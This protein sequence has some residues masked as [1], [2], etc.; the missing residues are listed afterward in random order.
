MKSILVLKRSSFGDI[1]HTMPVLPPLRRAFPEAKISWLTGV[2]Y[3]PLVLAAGTDEAI[4]IGFRTMFSSARARDYFGGLR[5]LRERFDVL[6]DFQGTVKSWLLLAAARARRKI[7]FDPADAREGA[8]ARFYSECAPPLPPGLHVIRQYLRL[9]R[10]LGIET[11]AIEFPELKIDPREESAVEKWLAERGVGEAAIVNPFAAWATKSWPPE[12]AAGFCRL[13]RQELGLTPIVLWGPLEKE[14]AERIVGMAGGAA[15]AAPQTTRT[16]LI[17]LLRRA[18]LYVGG[19]TGPTQLAAALGVPIVALFGPTDPQRNGP[20]SP[21]DDVIRVTLDCEGCQRNRCTLS[22]ETA[23]C[24][25][26]I[27]PEM[28]LEAARRRLGIS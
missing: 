3:G 6:I 1:V 26:R 9:L 15:L 13:L 10:P 22:R 24:M 27:S 5:R 17:A 19:D 25:S 11:E 21:E 18:R 12:N 7:G 14:R 23:E 20:F 16:Q 8:V 28:V 4:E 2:G